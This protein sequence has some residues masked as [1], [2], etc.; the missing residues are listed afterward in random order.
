MDHS[1]LGDAKTALEL[2]KMATEFGKKIV[3]LITK[4]KDRAIREDLEQLLDES[5]DLKH[6][7]I[8]LED[9]N[10][11]LKERLRFNEDEY[12]I[13]GIFRYHKDRP[14][15]PLCPKCFASRTIAYMSPPGED[16]AAPNYRRCTVCRAYV[17]IGPDR[18]YGSS[19][20]TP[21][22]GPWS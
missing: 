19:G 9:E 8:A 6:L 15:E 10:R 18:A 4:V 11:E 7:A 3:S 13:G 5:R 2:G 12:P 22:Y 16:G 21:D 1:H 17:K 20:G 14:H